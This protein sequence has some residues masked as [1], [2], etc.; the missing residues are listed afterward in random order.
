MFIDFHTHLD[1]YKN[2]TEL[3]SQLRSFEGIIVAA[4]INLESYK[5][6][7]EICRAVSGAVSGSPAGKSATERCHIIPTLGIHPENADDEAGRLQDYDIFLDNSP[8]IGEIG[9][10]FCWAKT[11][12]LNQ[13]KCFRYFLEHCSETKKYCVIHTKDAEEKIARILEEY[14][15]ARPVIH[16]YD[17]P[18]EIF[19]EFIR[20]GYYQTF[21]VETIRSPAIQK[22][23]RQTPPEL[24]LAET[25]NPTAE[26]W[27]GG[28]DSSVGLIRRVYGDLAAILKKSPEEIEARIKK[29]ALS[30]LNLPE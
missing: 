6:N 19:K 22:L 23:L 16:W 21:G 20:R 26:P 5:K 12:A 14:P 30:I 9:M 10:D 8:L 13:E 18:E 29:N 17:G 15:A 2:Q 3:I 27:L 24:L 25:D 4:S 7:L 28:N 1:W 11:S